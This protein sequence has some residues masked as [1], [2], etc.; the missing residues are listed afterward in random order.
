MAKI[1]FPAQCT[2][3]HFSVSET[4]TAAGFPNVG[5]VKIWGYFSK[6]K[7]CLYVVK[8][9]GLGACSIDCKV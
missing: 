6:I 3:R 2:A 8:V 7:S 4:G 1:D 5:L 9:K